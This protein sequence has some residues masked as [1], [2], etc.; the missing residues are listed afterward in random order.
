MA[1]LEQIL[2]EYD[3]SDDHASVPADAKNSTAALPEGGF[4]VN[5]DLVDAVSAGTTM[6]KC[7]VPKAVL[8]GGVDGQNAFMNEVCMFSLIVLTYDVIGSDV[9]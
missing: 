6:L 9:I 8:E 4:Q 7:Q 2:S 1:K 3:S 5:R